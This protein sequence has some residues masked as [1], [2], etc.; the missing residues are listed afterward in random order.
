MSRIN[1]RRGWILRVSPAE[2]TPGRRACAYVTVH[3]R[4]RL[5]PQDTRLRRPYPPG[6]TACNGGA[7]AKSARRAFHPHSAL[8]TRLLHAVA[9]PGLRADREPRRRRSP[10]GRERAAGRATVPSAATRMAARPAG[11]YDATRRYAQ[12]A[13]RAVLRARLL[14]GRR[15]V[16]VTAAAEVGP[17]LYDVLIGVAQRCVEE[18][19]GEG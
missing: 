2:V 15:R 1:S 12:R 8:R 14:A 5:L 10:R 13:P 17:R 11:F 7:S 16:D 3:P 9:E 19:R 4:R 6:P 18:R